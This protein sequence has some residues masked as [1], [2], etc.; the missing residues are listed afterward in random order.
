MMED[1]WMANNSD[2]GTEISTDRIY[3]R[4]VTGLKVDTRGFKL[5]SS[6]REK[7]ETKQR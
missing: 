7:T 2:G 6:S 1:R 4:Y 5:C 3:I